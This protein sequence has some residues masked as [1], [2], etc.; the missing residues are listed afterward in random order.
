LACYLAIFEVTLIDITASP[1]V[2]SFAG[3][4]AI[5]EVT[6]IDL[7]KENVRLLALTVKTI[8]FDTVSPAMTRHRK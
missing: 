2:L 6:L 1:C 7:A 3:S 5:F 8:A 4:L